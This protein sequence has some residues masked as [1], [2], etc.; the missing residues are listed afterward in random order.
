MLFPQILSVCLWS[1]SICINLYKLVNPPN[2]PHLSTRSEYPIALI[3]PRPLA[4][5]C[6]KMTDMLEPEPRIEVYH[7]RE[8]L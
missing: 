7:R 3:F 1:F 6:I 5:V 2:L 8:R 4:Q